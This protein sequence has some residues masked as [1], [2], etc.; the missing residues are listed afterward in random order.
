LLDLL[1]I[2]EF[3]YKNEEDTEQPHFGFIAQEIEANYPNLVVR[4]A[5]NNLRVKYIELIPLLLMYNK[6]LKND[7]NRIYEILG[8][9]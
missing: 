7:I 6:A 3:H 4:D 1:N 5:E 8:K 9:K 2:I